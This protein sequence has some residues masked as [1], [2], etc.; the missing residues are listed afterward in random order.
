[1]SAGGSHTLLVRNIHTLVTMDADDR[2]VRNAALLVR[3]G[4]IEQ[5]GRAEDLPD[6]ADE[7]LDRGQYIT[8]VLGTRL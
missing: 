6:T 5:L 2:E 8:A 7:V 3:G 1:M 4:V